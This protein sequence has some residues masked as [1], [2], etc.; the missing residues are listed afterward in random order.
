MRDL[1]DLPGGSWT[2]ESAEQF[3]EILT[4][5][6]GDDLYPAIDKIFR[7]AKQTELERV[8][9]DP[10]AEPDPLHAAV[11]PGGEP[12][13]GVGLALGRHR[14]SIVAEIVPGVGV[15]WPRHQ[16]PFLG[17]R[18]HF[19][20]VNDDRFMNFSRIMGVPHLGQGS[21]CMP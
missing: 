13:V 5:A 12:G 6:L 2:L 17:R 9:T 19:G 3:D 7:R 20:Q 14:V 10:P 4:D 21:P 15:A 8:A 18:W 11:H 16:R 1:C